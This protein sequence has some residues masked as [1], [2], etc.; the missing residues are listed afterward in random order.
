MV[1]CGIPCT[2]DI[3]DM[4]RQLENVIA[5]KKSKYGDSKNY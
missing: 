1:N 3:S 4:I 2:E 5:P